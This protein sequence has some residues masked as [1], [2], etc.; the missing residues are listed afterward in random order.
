VK[1][2]NPTGA[3]NERRTGSR[4]TTCGVQAKRGWEE[5]R[6][7]QALNFPDYRDRDAERNCQY[8]IPMFIRE[9]D[10]NQEPK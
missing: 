1:T 5:S 6:T 3:S 7:T 4:S 8:R 2:A 10:L 9:S